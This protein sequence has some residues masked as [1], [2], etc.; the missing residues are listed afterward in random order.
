MADLAAHHRVYAMDLL[1][2]GS[3]WLSRPPTREEGVQFSLDTW[4][5]QIQAFIDEVMG[6]GPVYVVGHA[7]L[8]G[9]D[10]CGAWDEG[11]RACWRG[12]GGATVGGGGACAGGRA[13]SA[14]ACQAR[15]L[16]T[17]SGG[18]WPRRSRR[19]GRTS[20]AGSSC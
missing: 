12:P 18:C 9:G 7:S 11:A 14:H 15:R 3:S 5:S 17:R 20:C 4:S 19:S 2:Q 10:G 8:R 1:G 13:E 16:A 6:G